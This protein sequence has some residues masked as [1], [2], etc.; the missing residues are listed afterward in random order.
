MIFKNKKESISEEDKKFIANK[1]N[2]LF[3]KM[4]NTDLSEKRIQLAAFIMNCKNSNGDTLQMANNVI[5]NELEYI[6]E[7]Q[8]R[9]IQDFK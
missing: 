5:Q 9:E 4:K 8:R 6:T 7:L 2:I 1:N 3:L